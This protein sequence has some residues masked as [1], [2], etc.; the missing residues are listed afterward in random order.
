MIFPAQTGSLPA[1]PACN[2][3][4]KAG[5][6]GTATVALP[7][8]TKGSP[9]W[10]APQK[11]DAGPHGKNQRGGRE[12]WL[13]C[14][15]FFL[16]F[17][18]VFRAV[19][20]E[21]RPP[22]RRPSTL[23][24]TSFGKASILPG[25]CSFFR[26]ARTASKLQ[27][28]AAASGPFPPLL[29]LLP[30]APLKSFGAV[31]LPLKSPSLRQDF[32][33]DGYGHN[34]HRNLPAA[35]LQGTCHSLFHPAA[36][37]HLHAHHRDAADVV[38]PEDGGQLFCVIDVVEL[39]AADERHAP[40]NKFFMEISKGIGRAVGG[41]QKVCAVKIGGVARNQPDLH[42]PLQKTALGL[43][44]SGAVAAIAL[45]PADGPPLR[46]GTPAGKR[47][48][49]RLLFCREHCRPVIGG[50]LAHLKG[51][52]S[53]RAR[54]QAVTQ[55]VTVVLS[56]ESGLAPC[57]GNGALMAGGGTRT[58]PV[59]LFLVN[60]NHFSF[61]FSVPFPSRVGCFPCF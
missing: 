59:T 58:T 39:G 61:H 17:Y 21:M 9:N 4:F 20:R 40:L 7:H 2:A 31:S 6:N 42:R 51:N 12:L 14:R 11:K 50:R 46:A 10:K 60:F 52:G 32:P 13:P 8:P 3:P 18:L 23:C 53:R 37:G 24:A 49:L 1:A 38:F 5:R 43:P 35:C 48:G 33:I 26:E 19:I 29:H 54:R 36:A 25:T 56:H 45:L 55:P 41:H 47:I 30:K 15:P 16:I 44:P 57:H 34:L 22:I 27:P 28:P